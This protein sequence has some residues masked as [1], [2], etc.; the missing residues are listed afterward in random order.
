MHLS[1]LFNLL[2]KSAHAPQAGQS[3][4]WLNMNELYE[5][6]AFLLDFSSLCCV[7]CHFHLSFVF[8]KK[9]M[10]HSLLA[11]FTCNFIEINK[12]NKAC[13]ISNAPESFQPPMFLHS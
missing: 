5:P 4:T 6:V 11:V 8:I 7:F 1:V 10:T 3:Q 2:V 13:G 9:A 12:K